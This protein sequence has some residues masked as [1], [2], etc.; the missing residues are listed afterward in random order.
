[1]KHKRKKHLSGYMGDALPPSWMLTWSIN[2]TAGCWSTGTECPSFASATANSVGR[3]RSR[4]PCL[5]TIVN[6]HA[7]CFVWQCSIPQG[8][9]IYCR[10][11]SGPSIDHDT[12]TRE[13]IYVLPDGHLRFLHNAAAGGCW[14]FHSATAHL[15][16]VAKSLRIGE[17]M[18]VPNQHIRPGTHGK[19]PLGP[20]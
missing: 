16:L 12:P 11:G 6:V 13:K 20:S 7:M 8:S 17:E 9:S 2:R 3:R 18:V 19:I 14:N 1:M 15:E 10:S 5:P 4:S